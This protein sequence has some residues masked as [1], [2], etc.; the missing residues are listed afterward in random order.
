M[1][2]EFREMLS[3]GFHG[4]PRGC[5]ARQI[6]TGETGGADPRG[7]EVKPTYGPI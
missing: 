7:K 4:I 1:E 5:A 2:G 6:K 3:N